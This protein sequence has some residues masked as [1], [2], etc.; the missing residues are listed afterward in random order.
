MQAKSTQHVTAL[1]HDLLCRELFSALQANKLSG[2]PAASAAA[3]A[4]Q[5]E[6]VKPAEEPGKAQPKGGAWWQWLLVSSVFACC[7]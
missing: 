3:A 2:A 5:A 6:E 7:A 4:G 1:R